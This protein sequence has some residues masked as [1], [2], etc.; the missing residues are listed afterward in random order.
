MINRM[1]LVI[2][3]TPFS[4]RYA[5]WIIEILNAPY[6]VCLQLPR[7]DLT[8]PSIKQLQSKVQHK[9]IW[10]IS[11]L[12]LGFLFLQYNK[13]TLFCINYVI[14]LLCSILSLFKIETKIVRLL[15]LAHTQ[16]S[17]ILFSLRKL[18]FLMKA[19]STTQL[20]LKSKRPWWLH[21]LLVELNPKAFALSFVVFLCKI[22]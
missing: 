8:L 3:L 21:C 12:F 22:T 9:A 7:F 4:D 2:H 1:L 17:I 14:M 16:Y 5:P 11:R 6:L 13:G 18:Q 19:F 20:L 10:Y 15:R